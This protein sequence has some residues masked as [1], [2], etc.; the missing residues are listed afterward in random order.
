MAHQPIWAKARASFSYRENP[1]TK[2]DW[3]ASSSSSARDGTEDDLMIAQVL[4]EEISG[5][6]S[7]NAL[8]RRLSH[9]SSIPV[10]SFY[11]SIK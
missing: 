5:G 4:S 8:A 9:L 2:S 1:T 10:S 6:S 11:F 7:D 3:A